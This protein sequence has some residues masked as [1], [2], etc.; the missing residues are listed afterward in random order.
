MF[1]KRY[2]LGCLAHASYMIGDEKTR[3]AVVVDPQRDVGQYVDDAHGLDFSIRHVMLTHLHADFVAGHL[4]LRNREGASIYLGARAKTEY[5]F[6][7]MPDGFILD[8]GTVRLKVLETPGH[9]PES[10]SIL[11]YDLTADAEK[12]YAVLTGDLLFIGD[13]GRPDLHGTRGWTVEQLG[14]MLYDSLREKILT[15][16]DETRVYPAHGAGSLCGKNLG[17]E[18][19][20]TVGI[21]RRLNYA[22]QPMTK[23]QFITLVSADQPDAPCYF[24][25]DAVLNTKERSTLD[26]ALSKAL[27]PLSLDRLL[28][29]Q[30]QGVQILDVREPEEFAGGHLSGSLNVPLSGKYATWAGTILKPGDPVAIIAAE[31]RQE[32]AAMRLGRIGYD[33]I[34]GYL[35]GGMRALELRP[36]F[37]RQ[38]RRITVPMLMEYLAAPDPPLVLDVR[39]E[40]EVS[41]KRIPGSLNIPLQRLREHIGELP[42]GKMVVV[43]C[44]CG[45]RSSIAASLLEQHGL[46]ECADLAGGIEAW[47]THRPSSTVGMI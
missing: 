2:Y 26:V 25:Y 19:F 20:S 22:L 5:P 41:V 31:G 27:I 28:E 43:H 34:A 35:P 10:V 32:E 6:I 24:V 21:Q 37:V 8:L 47:E 23:K 45:Y 1:F 39:T 40:S 42:L 29:M 15:L 14:G 33:T 38:T 3:A 36:E 9:S 7:P 16:P 30:S 13:V 11:L 12:P 46:Q 17:D 44:E 18:E 4:E